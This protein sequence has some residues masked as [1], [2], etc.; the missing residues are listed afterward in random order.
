LFLKT[1]PFGDWTMATTRDAITFNYNPGNGDIRAEIERVRTAAE[2]DYV[3]EPIA[4]I[5]ET[6]LREWIQSKLDAPAGTKLRIKPD[7]S[8]MSESIT[9]SYKTDGGSIKTLIDELRVRYPTLKRR[10]VSQ[11]CVAALREWLPRH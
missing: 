3:G 10:S 4:S 6:A 8:P 2:S 5:C 11:I 7:E 9:F 1:L